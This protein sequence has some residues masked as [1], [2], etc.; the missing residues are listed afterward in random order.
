LTLC[1]G[2]VSIAVIKVK[3]VLLQG[4]D[5]PGGAFAAHIPY[6]S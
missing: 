1:F 6:G 3:T 4:V 5:K 2:I